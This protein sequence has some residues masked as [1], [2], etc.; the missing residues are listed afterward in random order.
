METPMMYIN[1]M[2]DYMKIVNPNPLE[3]GGF[4]EWNSVMIGKPRGWGES[5]SHGLN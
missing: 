3:T 2:F 1:Q 5:G 4:C